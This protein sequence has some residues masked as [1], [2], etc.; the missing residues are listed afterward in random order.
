[1]LR[2]MKVGTKL[3]AILLAPTIVIVAL[4]AVG[5]RD[6]RAAAD[7]AARVED[8]ST[9]ALAVS[10]LQAHVEREQ[11]LS[12]VVS[13][14]GDEAARAELDKQRDRTD[15]ALARYR[16]ATERVATGQ[17]GDALS[18]AAG[19]A[20]TRL[21]NL[22]A[23][24]RT[25]DDS[26]NQPY[27]VALIYGDVVDT[28]VGVNATLAGY[29]DDSELLKGLDAMAR[30][31][32]LRGRQ[33]NQATLLVGAAQKGAFTDGDGNVCASVTTDCETWTR[34]GV[35]SQELSRSRETMATSGATS[36]QKS[37]VVNAEGLSEYQGLANQVTED[38]EAG[39]AITVSGQDMLAASI[40][41]LDGLSAADTS[42]TQQIVDEAR[43]QESDASQAVLLFMLFGAGGVAVAFAIAVV[44]GRSI[45]RPLHRLT[46]AAAALSTEQLPALVE[47]LRNPEDEDEEL[48]APDP[49]AVDS[50][51]E[52]GELA[53]AFNSIQ[54]VTV[55]VAEEQG[56]L[57]R[58]G[59][60]DIFV[61]LARRNQSLLDRQIEFI[62]QLENAER[63]PDQLENLFRLD[64]LATRMRRN[65]ES[66]L[67]MAGADP[68]RRRGQPVPVSDVVRVA[69]GEV[70]D[71][72]RIDLLAL[73][74]ATVAVNVAS[75]LAHLLSELMENATNASPPDTTVEVLGGYDSRNGYVITVADRGIGMTPDQLAE[76]NHQLAH[77]PMVGLVISRSLGLTVVGRLAARYGLTVHLQARD[78]GGVVA[79]VELPYGTVEY[80]GEANEPQV[81]PLD[82]AG[83]PGSPAPR[84]RRGRVTTAVAAA[85]APSAPELLDRWAD[86]DELTQLRPIDDVPTVPP[87]HLPRRNGTAP[88]ATPAPTDAP[89]P[90]A[91]PDLTPSEPQA[92]PAPEPAPTLTAAGLVR[93]T[94]RARTGPEPTVPAG[95]PAVA[96][97]TRSPDEVRRMLSRYRSGLDRG[98]GDIPPSGD[99]PSPPAQGPKE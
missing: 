24:R 8:L 20:E 4:V 83:R 6:R 53:G 84:L 77:P 64:H 98:R 70:E 89:A 16:D 66:L 91:E 46:A 35:A 58:K 26:P 1:M 76:A 40:G 2:N 81:D 25:I 88:T 9:Y 85:P 78:G 28:V 86:D 5:V 50:K 11:L 57:L 3:L 65:A 33:V 61:N 14:G 42:L 75:D 87:G 73:D 54:A 36:E 68:P 29:A 43:A 80:P 90:V 17:K 56:R 92:D 47:Q 34:A 52:I 99:H 93:R 7:D 60:G 49:I 18:Q 38:G 10:D 59:I 72:Q 79:T 19:V 96:R 32:Q 95:A 62:D 63:D 97:T 41:A 71:F 27:S 15:A 37:A 23:I 67:V 44:V 74:D 69:I 30:L 13:A 31:E 55:E 48:I 82:L 22:S 45:T 39:N 51:D 94:P 12:A 21:S